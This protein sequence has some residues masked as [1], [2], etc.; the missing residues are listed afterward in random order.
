MQTDS[1][2]IWSREVLSSPSTSQHQATTQTWCLLSII[3]TEKHRTVTGMLLFF[4][5]LVDVNWGLVHDTFLWVFMFNVALYLMQKWKNG[6]LKIMAGLSSE[7]FS[8]T[9]KEKLD[10]SMKAC[11][12]LATCSPANVSN[13]CDRCM[14]CLC[15]HKA[16]IFTVMAWTSHV[17][18]RFYNP[19]LRGAFSSVDL[20]QRSERLLI[21]PKPIQAFARYVNR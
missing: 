21:R 20:S 2:H 18:L 6:A 11:L 8:Y 16:T 12:R 13:I 14:V 3:P 15:S 19:F 4:C 5:L 17:Q 9:L 10:A 7:P 1:I